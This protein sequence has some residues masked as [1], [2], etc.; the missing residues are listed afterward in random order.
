MGELA[1]MQ[2]SPTYRLALPF[3]QEAW[4]QLE[5]ANG[6]GLVSPPRKIQ[7][8]IKHLSP[9]QVLQLLEA[10]KDHPQKTL[11][12]L[13]LTTGMRRGE[14]LGLKWQDIDFAKGIFQVRRALTRMSTGLGYK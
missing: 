3:S 1:L 6:L 2:T 12:I 9:E 5:Y 8:E 13:A 4:R 10:A 11:F 14:L 7:K